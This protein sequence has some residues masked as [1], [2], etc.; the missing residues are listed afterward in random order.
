MGNRY[1]KSNFIFRLCIKRHFVLARSRDKS[2]TLYSAPTAQRLHGLSSATVSQRQADVLTGT[3]FSSS[4]FCA[5]KLRSGATAVH[6]K[7]RPGDYLTICWQQHPCLVKLSCWTT[8]CYF[9]RPQTTST[10]Q[11]FFVSVFPG[12]AWPGTLGIQCCVQRSDCCS[13]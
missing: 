6:L 5:T 8:V 11:V 4:S 3:R 1:K 13:S 12:M 7:R 9:L 10:H 2:S